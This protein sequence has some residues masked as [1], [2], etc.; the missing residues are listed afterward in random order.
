MIAS[1]VYMSNC[2]E[3]IGIVNILLGLIFV[4]LSQQGIYVSAFPPFSLN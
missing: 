4:Q 3:R 2:H 1:C